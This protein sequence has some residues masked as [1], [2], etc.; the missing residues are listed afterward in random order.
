MPQFPSGGG[1]GGGSAI[2]KDGDPV[3]EQLAGNES[4]TVPTGETWVVTL[5]AFSGS[6]NNGSASINDQ[7][8]MTAESADFHDARMVLQA[9][10]TVQASGKDGGLGGMT[11]SGW[12]V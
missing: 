10:D 7:S 6:G 3:S 11:I 5:T 8:V 9:G 12:S 1:G 2:Y 4:I